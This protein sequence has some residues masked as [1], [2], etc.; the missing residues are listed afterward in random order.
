M[1][2]RRDC[3]VSERS[4]F[5]T[6]RG[7]RAAVSR[8]DACGVHWAKCPVWAHCEDGRGGGRI[9]AGSAVVSA[10]GGVLGPDYNPRDHPIIVVGRTADGSD[11]SL[12][13]VF[14]P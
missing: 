1:T 13:I 14:P 3:R 2:R 5:M 9:A 11:A 8:D 7:W 10:A 6:H 12:E 4:R